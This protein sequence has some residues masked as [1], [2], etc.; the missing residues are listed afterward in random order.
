ME[1][2]QQPSSVTEAALNAMS[3]TLQRRGYLTTEWWTTVAAAGLSLLLAIVGVN[4]PVAFQ[5]TAVLAP[6][7]V[8]SI[9]AVVRTVHKSA[10]AKL[11]ASD[12]L[13]ASASDPV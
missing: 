3:T 4:G 2:A 1:T 10:M 5:I 12:L 7:L 8:A 9:Y 11:L 6:V 13:P